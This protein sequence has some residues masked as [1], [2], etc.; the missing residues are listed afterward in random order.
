MAELPN[1][2]NCGNAA[3]VWV[4]INVDDVYVASFDESGTQTSVAGNPIL[5]NRIYRCA[6]CMGR[7]A[8]LVLEIDGEGTADESWHLDA[9]RPEVSDGK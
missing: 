9:Y 3:P 6:A 5:G 4:V 8:D 7:R 2:P 1:C